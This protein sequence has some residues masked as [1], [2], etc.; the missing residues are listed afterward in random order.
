MKA[1]LV[2]ATLVLLLAVG[3][4]DDRPVRP[5]PANASRIE[6][7]KL[8]NGQFLFLRTVIG[9]GAGATGRKLPPG[10]V[11]VDAAPVKIVFTDSTLDVLRPAPRRIEAASDRESVRVA[12][13]RA[14]SVDVM[15]KRTLDDRLVAEEE[16]TDL[17]RPAAE[18]THAVVDFTDLP[19]GPLAAQVRQSTL[20]EPPRWIDDDNLT[21]LVQRTLTDGSEVR[22]RLAFRRLRTEPFVSRPYDQT[23]MKRFGFFKRR[24]LSADAD[25]ETTLANAETWAAR[26]PQKKKLVLTVAPDVPATWRSAMRDVVKEWNDAIVVNGILPGVELAEAPIGFAD[27]SVNGVYRVE[28]P[29]PSEHDLLAY[30]S[31]VVREDRGEIV[32]ANI[33]LYAGGLRKF[34]HYLRARGEGGAMPVPTDKSAPFS[35]PSLPSTVLPSPL[36][37]PRLLAAMGIATATSKEERS[38]TMGMLREPQSTSGPVDFRRC[39]LRASDAEIDH[40][41]QQAAGKAGVDEG[42]AM[43]VRWLFAHELGHALGLRHNF[44]A[45]ADKPHFEG[46][47]RTTSVEDYLASPP[48]FVIGNYDVAALN[49]LYREDKQLDERHFWFCTELDP[50]DRRGTPDPL[51]AAYDEGTTLGEAVTFHTNRYKRDYRWLNERRGRVRFPEGPDGETRY[52]HAIHERLMPLRKIVD[53]GIAAAAANRRKDLGRLWL[54]FGPRVEAD[55]KTDAPDR[56]ALR[57]PGGRTV[58]LDRERVRSVL[59]DAVSAGESAAR[60]LSRLVD[61]GEGS[62]RPDLDELEPSSGRIERLGI[63]RD[64]AIALLLLSLPSPSPLADGEVT[65]PLATEEASTIEAFTRVISGTEPPTADSKSGFRTRAPVPAPSAL[66]YFAIELLRRLRDESNLLAP[67]VRGLLPVGPS[68]ADPH[69]LRRWHAAAMAERA[70]DEPARLGTYLLTIAPRTALDAV[71]LL[72]AADHTHKPGV[73]PKLPEAEQEDY[74]RLVA[75]ALLEDRWVA[76]AANALSVGRSITDDFRDGWQKDRSEV[77][78]TFAPTANGMSYY[79]SPCYKT[80]SGKTPITCFWLRDNIA[81]LR[82]HLAAH[83]QNEDR[84]KKFAVRPAETSDELRTTSAWLGEETA[85]LESAAR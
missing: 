17:R 65:S 30:A 75:I 57:L 37:L 26:W 21:L 38:P 1:R 42:E 71:A 28:E 43:M 77:P 47:A 73:Q 48:K 62:R 44:L 80:A 79:K 50:E 68:T 8:T 45:S 13:F 72:A 39:G 76:E 24:H 15:R 19:F 78:W 25:D 56:E 10:G 46:G 69:A 3:C 33:Y 9:A 53:A 11:L 4:G 29:L 81:R 67:V 49:A 63:L 61:T 74:R 20:L 82:L 58:W 2:L 70:K 85:L 66:R 7:S 83:Q 12:S 32:N 59:T 41:A 55:D 40:W 52:V 35:T 27:P 51:C 16:E 64:R 60:I 54:I 36:S 14:R 31:I 6:K 23:L 18:R 84:L 22:E 5:A 34:R